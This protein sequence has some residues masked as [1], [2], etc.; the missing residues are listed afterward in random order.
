LCVLGMYALPALADKKDEFKKAAAVN[1]PSCE[2]I[3]YGDLYGN[4]RDAYR[5][6][7]PWCTGE[8][9]LGCPG[10]KQADP[11]DREIA[12]ERRD[13][14]AE[15]IKKRHYT[16]DKFIAALSRLESDNDNDPEIRGYIDTIK[17]KIK[18]SIQ[19]HGD[20]IGEVE[21]R[22]RKCDNVYNQRD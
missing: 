19:K 8:K 12:K 7:T 11:R 9:E 17:E 4:C 5:E 21:N 3:P 14:A 16:I 20:A 22:Q 15:C 6:Q 13:N 1:G 18:A 2:L 10:L